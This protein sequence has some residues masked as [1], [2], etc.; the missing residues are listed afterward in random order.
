MH[1]FP[2]AILTELTTV[3]CPGQSFQPSHQTR[4]ADDCSSGASE[5]VNMLGKSL[6]CITECST[7]SLKASRQI[8]AVSPVSSALGDVD[9]LLDATCVGQG[10]GV[11]HVFAGDLVQGATD[12]RHGLVRQQGGVPP[13]EAIDQVPH[14][15]LP[16]EGRGKVRHA[17]NKL[18]HTVQRVSEQKPMNRERAWGSCLTYRHLLHFFFY[19]LHNASVDVRHSDRNYILFFLYHELY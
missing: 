17:A 18:R 13:R 8:H 5:H 3:K 10:L 4:M 14:C 6:F 16:W 12:G 19:M 1:T 2:V 9:Q 15:I 11:L 7:A